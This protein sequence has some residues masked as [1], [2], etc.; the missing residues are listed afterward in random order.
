[1]TPRGKKLLKDLLDFLFNTNTDIPSEYDRGIKKQM[2]NKFNILTQYN[3]YRSENFFKVGNVDIHSGLD[4][5]LSQTFINYIS[6]GGKTRKSR[7]SR[8][9]KKS[10]K[11]RKNK[12]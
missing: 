7:K 2:V 3:F 12:K 9:S 1:M 4:S 6:G 8:Q 10:R 5:L 11:S